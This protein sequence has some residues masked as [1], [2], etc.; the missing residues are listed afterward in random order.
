METL[1]E[2]IEYARGKDKNHDYDCLLKAYEGVN[3][4]I[5]KLKGPAGMA[6]FDTIYI[7]PRIY[8]RYGAV[9]FN[10]VLLHELCHHKRYL[11]YGTDFHMKGLSLEN[12]DEFLDFIINEEITADRYAT[13][14]YRILNGKTFSGKTQELHK[15]LN[16][17]KYEIVAEYIFGQIQNDYDNYN[18][19]AESVLE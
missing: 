7:D 5:R 9:M 8:D 16:R 15:P 12:F 17:K 19:L 10:F 2:V 14:M 4:Q 11:K 1:Q 3:V 18:K 6:T 13:Y